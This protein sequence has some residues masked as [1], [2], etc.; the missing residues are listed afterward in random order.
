MPPRLRRLIGAVLLI[1]LVIAYPFLVVVFAAA[2]LP[3]SSG[4]TQLIFYM[5]GGLIWVPP[6]GLIIWWMGRRPKRP[7]A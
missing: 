5:V 3:G 7:T 6:A 1:I 2:L 4:L